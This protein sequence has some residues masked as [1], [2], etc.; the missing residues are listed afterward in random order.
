MPSFIIKY[1]KL[2]RNFGNLTLTTGLTDKQIVWIKNK[3]AQ[4]EAWKDTA[5]IEIVSIKSRIS[6]LETKVANA[7]IKFN[8]IDA[9]LSAIEARLTAHGI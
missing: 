9:R 7:V 1:K 4:V 6:V 3:V 2:V 8:Q 5:A